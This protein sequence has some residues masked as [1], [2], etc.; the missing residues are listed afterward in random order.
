MRIT[1]VAEAPHS[2]ALGSP[3]NRS[4]LPYFYLD[5]FVKGNDFGSTKP[6]SSGLEASF[7]PSDLLGLFGAKS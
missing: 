4:N 5:H 3:E 2:F 6:G 7:T 1:T